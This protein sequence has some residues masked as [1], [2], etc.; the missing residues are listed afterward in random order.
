MLTVLLAASLAPAIATASSETYELALVTDLGTIDDRSFNQ[1]SWEGLV[2][3]AEENGISYKYYQPKEQSDDAYLDSIQLAV[4][5]GAKLVVTPGFLFETPV[6]IAQ[7]MYPDVNFVLIDGNPHSADYAEYRTESNAVGIIYAEEQSGFLAGYAVVK[8]GYTK[9]GFMG[10]MA[11]PAVVRF[12]YGFV[13]GAE[14]AAKELG[15]DG[16]SVNYHYTGA[17]AASPEAQALAATWYNDGVEVIFG[18]GGKLGNSVMAAAEAAA[19]K[20]V[21]G[22]DVDQSS[23]SDRV[24]TSAVKGLRESVYQAIDA[25]YKGEFPGGEAWVLGAD[26]QGV[27]LPMEASKFTAF[28]QDDY[29]AIYAKLVAGEVSLKKDADAESA[30]ELSSDIVTVTVVK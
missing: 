22:V 12:G 25:A 29:D 1:G 27:G 18:C 14:Y 20:W 16:V 5:S 7:D 11:V 15:I 10:G 21:V 9:L 6:F 2:Q 13:Q 3:Y 23:E 30:D 4:E 24:I 17:F 28:T 26:R 19:D 8:D